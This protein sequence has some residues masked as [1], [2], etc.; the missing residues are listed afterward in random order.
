MH[1]DEPIT[2][3]KAFAAKQYSVK[4]SA[5]INIWPTFWNERKSSLTNG[6]TTLEVTAIAYSGDAHLIYPTEY[7]AGTTPGINDNNGLA[8]SDTLAYKL[9]KS[10]NVIGMEIKIDNQKRI[11]RG[12]FEGKSDLVL[13]SYSSEDI[14]ATWTSVDFQGDREITRN[15]AEN[16]SIASGLGMPE[17]ISA[18]SHIILSNI[19]SILPLLVLFI[20]GFVMIR[21]FIKKQYPAFYVPLLF[22]LFILFAF[23]L[24][25][26]L[27]ALPAYV[28]P[29]RWSDFLFWSRLFELISD[30][31]YEFLNTTTGIR[32]AELRMLLLKQTGI[33]LLAINCALIICAR[34]K[35]AI[36]A[37]S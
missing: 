27:S 17:K 16:F 15:E 22:G 21:G 3:Q 9:F 36:N 28:V 11:I 4:N 32:D 33:S 13:V 10:T 31:I 23:I 20:Y 8:I 25:S 12:V 29:T 6:Y 37:A 34:Q 30:D 24:P 18:G 26:L 19:I 2:G 5:I 7:I 1:F 14:S 35:G